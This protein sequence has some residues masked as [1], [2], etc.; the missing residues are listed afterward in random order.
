MDPI[1]DRGPAPSY[2]DPPQ[3]PDMIE[4]GTCDGDGY[5]GCTPQ[6]FAV[7]DPKTG[8][9]VRDRICLENHFCPMC[10]G[11]GEMQMTPEMERD[12]QDAAAEARWE[13]AR[14]DRMGEDKE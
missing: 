3:E 6:C 8:I 9:R 11:E 2:Y 10:L 14:E 1:K 5:M 13:C 7:C 12:A 4:C